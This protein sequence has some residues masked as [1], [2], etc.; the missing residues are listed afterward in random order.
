MSSSTQA[1]YDFNENLLINWLKQ[2]RALYKAPLQT[3]ILVSLGIFGLQVGAFWWLTSLADTII[4]QSTSPYIQDLRFLGIT[5]VLILLLTKIKD[6]LVGRIHH[7]IC[8]GLQTQ[9]QHQMEH[10][11]FVMRQEENNFFWQQL[12]LDHIPAVGNYVTYYSIQKRIAA[13]TPLIAI[14]IIWPVNGSVALTL[15][16]AIAAFSS[17]IY[18]KK[19]RA[20]NLAS[21]KLGEPKVK[22]ATVTFLSRSFLNLFSV[23]AMVMVA[24]FVGFSFVGETFLSD[25]I[26]LHQGLFLLLFAPQMFTEL[27]KLKK[28]Y[29][30]KATAVTAAQNILPL[31]DLQYLE[32]VN[33]QSTPK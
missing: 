15:L 14:A 21:I 4:M 3:A 16:I 5:I 18:I 9:L 7:S 32:R 1:I 22:A 28:L 10:E 27:K 19:K 26:G 31:Y 2:Q 13:I 30:Q 33:L 11:S 20:L 17:S 12:W 24:T 25:Q 6:G 8:V 29:H 23:F